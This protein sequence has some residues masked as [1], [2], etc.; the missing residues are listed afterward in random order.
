M[1]AF[2]IDSRE[3]RIAE[4][5][6]EVGRRWNWEADLGESIVPNQMEITVKGE[7][8]G[9]LDT[10]DLRIVEYAERRNIAFV[11]HPDAGA[12]TLL[13]ATGAEVPNGGDLEWDGM[14]GV[15]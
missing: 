3:V 6:M 12:T 8:V 4:L 13:A 14:G 10:K 5:T 9:Y 15:A 7:P 1:V 2:S 11:G